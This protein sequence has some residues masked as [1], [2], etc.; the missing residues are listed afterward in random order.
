MFRIVPVVLHGKSTRFETFAF[1]DEG[2]EL[3]L[4]DAEIADALGLQGESRPLC[5]KWTSGVTRDESDSKQ[6]TLEISGVN[7]E[8]R[9]PLVNVRTVHR[10][11][12]PTQTL[13]FDRLAANYPHLQKLP[14]QS[15]ENVTPKLLIGLN[16]LQ[17]AL[18]L[19]CRTGRGNE[20]VAAK[21]KL[22]WTVFGS[23]AESDSAHSFHVGDCTKDGD[24]HEHE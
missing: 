11:D 13:E 14:V 7:N 16:N 15:Y 23:T 6:I 2:S 19:K 10:L 20:P 17:L 1:L 12:L 24:L 22:G 4:M 3:T 21:M 8:K 5:L 18:P 9:F